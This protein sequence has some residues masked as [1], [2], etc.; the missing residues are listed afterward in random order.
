MYSNKE[1]SK[2]QAEFWTTFGLYMRPVPG[3]HGERVNW[4]NYKT[5][6]KHL[7]FNLLFT[8]NF[9]S[10]KIIFAHPELDK[11]ISFLKTFYIFKSELKSFPQPLILSKGFSISEPTT[12]ECVLNNVNIFNKETWPAAITFLKETMVQ[13]DVFWQNNKYVF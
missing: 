6:I 13:L 9:A 3:V 1:I 2:I 8:D 10:L 12:I 4:I 7:S 11:Q 5:H